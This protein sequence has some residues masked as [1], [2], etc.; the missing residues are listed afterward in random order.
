MPYLTGVTTDIEKALIF[1]KF[2]A[3]F[4]ALS[5]VFGKDPRYWYRIEQ[6]LGRNSIVG[7]SAKD[8]DDIPE[9]LGADEKHT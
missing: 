8:P 7:T 1:R 5:H 4:W 3:P 9:H 2:S 6:R